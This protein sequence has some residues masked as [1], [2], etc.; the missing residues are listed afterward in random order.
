[1]EIQVAAAKVGKY[2]TRE[3][4]DTFEVVERPH[5]GLSF[6]LAD[7]QRSGKGAK[8]ISNIVARKAISLLAEGV[9]DGVVARAAHDYL[10]TQRAAQ[11]ISTLNMV[12]M[13]LATRTLVISRNNPSPVY[14][15]QPGG[16][17]PL[18]EPSQPIGVHRGTKPHIT[19][20]PIEPNMFVVVFTDGIDGAGMRY[21]LKLDLPKLITDYVEAET[22]GGGRPESAQA[23]ADLILAEAL[24]LDQGRPNDDMSVVVVAVLPRSLGD[25]ARRMTLHFPLEG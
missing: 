14:V 7:G 25:G 8:S 10:Y 19:E 2:A 23:L 21:G 1:M 15:V 24:K 5:G 16:L 13:D 3:S 4:G 6:V 17:R 20:L 11:V 18:D 9:R 22:R 12:S